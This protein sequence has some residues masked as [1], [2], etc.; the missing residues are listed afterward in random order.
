MITP[1]TPV[2]ESEPRTAIKGWQLGAVFGA[3][4]VL[5]SVGY[6]VGG[7]LRNIVFASLES[8][9]FTVLALLAYIGID[10]LWGKVLALLLLAGLIGAVAL[11]SLVYTIAAVMEGGLVNP[12]LQMVAGG[13]TRLLVVVGLSV[14]A[15]GIGALGFLP[16]VRER[17]RGVLP[18]DPRSFV[19]MVA[20]VM[21]VTATLL[22]F[23]PLI[24]LGEPP[25]LVAIAKLPEDVDLAGGRTEYGQLRD[26][27]YGLAWTIP[28]AIIAVG[29]AIRRNFGA[30][31]TRLGFVRPTMQQV[32][33]GIGLAVAL[34]VAVQ[35][36]GLGIDWVW[37]RLGL[38][39]TDT[40]AFGEMLKFAMSPAGAVVIGITAGLGEELA[41][42]GVLQPRLGILLS[43]LFFTGLHAFQ[44]N[45]DS[46]LVVF[47]VGM[48]LGVLR[49]R[50]NTTTS[51]IV[52]GV[53][54]FLLIIAAVYEV[55]WF[56]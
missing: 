46:L 50:T 22:C 30:A 27:F 25:A 10:R 23:I 3:L 28:G 52:H 21:V 53:Y 38:R 56:S 18:L 6:L 35:I 31:M 32:L 55:P 2:L 5:L 48:V 15:L 14:L 29:Y 42:R 33:A 9:P 26:R 40:E 20:L 54:N 7:E 37:E 39:K 24:V 47:L 43:N 1:S 12:S 4:V 8:L 16:Q 11:L 41:V 13:G 51:A 49:K 45:W 19:H 17:L 34:V 36:L 44:Y